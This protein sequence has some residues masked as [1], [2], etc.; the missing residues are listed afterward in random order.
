MKKKLSALMMYL[1]LAAV[2]SAGPDLGFS[3]DAGGHWS[4]DAASISGEGTFTFVQPVTI[5]L[6]EGQTLDALIGAYV[7]LPEFYVSNLMQ[8]YPGVYSGQIAPTSLF[9]IQD[10]LGNDVFKGT[11]AVGGIFTIGTTALM[12]SSVDFDLT[13][14]ELDNVPGSGF[15]SQL[16]VGDVLDFD[17]TLQ[18][19]DMATMILNNRDNLVGNTFSGSM[20]LIPEPATLAILAIGGLLL[21]KRHK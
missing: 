14:T 20:T 21:R 4:Y 12:Y 6:V 1:C 2:V 15:L 16:Q 7:F 5:D 8:V 13:I 3:S 9:V 17:M 11:M 18:G 10:S 19:K